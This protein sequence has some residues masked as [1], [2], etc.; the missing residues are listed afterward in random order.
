[1][2]SLMSSTPRR[3]ASSI[4][5]SSTSWR[6]SGLCI[7][8]SGIE[9]SSIAIVSLMPGF[10]S[11]LR[12]SEPWGWSSACRMWLRSPRSRGSESGG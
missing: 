4:T 6:M 10:R 2:V 11:S 12:G 1:M 3:A 5:S 8:G 9:M 7:G